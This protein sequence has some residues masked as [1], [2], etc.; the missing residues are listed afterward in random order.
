MKQIPQIKKHMT[1]MPHTIGADISLKKAKAMMT[2]HGIRHLPVLDG[3]TLVGVL[4]DRDI[5]LASSLG[6]NETTVEDVMMPDPFVVE[7][8]AALDQVVGEMA[9]KKYG[10]A[11][12]QQANGTVVGIFTAV[13]GLRVLSET[14]HAFYKSGS[15]DS[16]GKR[17]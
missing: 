4:T 7:P 8:E 14:L 5:K 2:E 11:I 13:D 16:S 12:I 15:D 3:G 9:E 17:R 6:G 1:F 10:S